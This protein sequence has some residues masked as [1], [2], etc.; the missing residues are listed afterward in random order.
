MINFDTLLTKVGGADALCERL[1]LS[2]ENLRLMKHR[3]YFPRKHWLEIIEAFPQV[4]HS[5]LKFLEA[6]SKA[7]AERVLP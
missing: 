7:A 2:S 4:N 1:N 3:G 6:T 5:D